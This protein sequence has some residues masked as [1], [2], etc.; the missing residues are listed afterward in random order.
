M[1]KP[2]W[3]RW[4]TKVLSSIPRVV[5]VPPFASS[6]V[7][8]IDVIFSHLECL[9]VFQSEIGEQLGLRMIMSFHVFLATV[10][11]AQLGIL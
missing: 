2:D 3:R 7:G 5:E 8:W 1:A 6:D 10:V 9:R 11:M 4:K